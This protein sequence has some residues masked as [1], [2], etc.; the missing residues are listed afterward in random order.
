M[1]NLLNQINPPQAD[2]VIVIA[3]P[4]ASGKTA[5]SIQIALKFNGEV[6]SA[7]SRQVYRGLDIGSAK[8]TNS[9]MC[10]VPHHLI[11]VLDPGQKYSVAQ[12]QN[13]TLSLIKDI[14][15]REKVPIIC[16]GTGLYIESVV[17][18]YQFGENRNLTSS[19]S[20]AG[21][22]S[23]SKLKLGY[24]PKFKVYLLNWPREVLRQRISTRVD[25]RME[26]GM[27]DEVQNL[28]KRGV[29]PQW[30][31]SLGLEYRYLTEYLLDSNPNLDETITKLKFKIYQFAK[32][33]DTWFRRWNYAEVIEM[34]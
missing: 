1:K 11:D 27:L 17:E 5:L 30:L 26:E 24:D 28:I 33:Q 2:E 29:D 22:G 20:P 3:G 14:Q 23:D 25:Q 12:F 16:G 6:I 8:V 18:G 9:E 21:E 15:A 7:D 34:T 32:R 10:G 31:I 13:Q 19:P 4:T